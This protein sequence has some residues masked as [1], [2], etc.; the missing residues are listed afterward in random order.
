[1]ALSLRTIYFKEGSAGLNDRGMDHRAAQ[2][3]THIAKMVL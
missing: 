3:R 2:L 1:M